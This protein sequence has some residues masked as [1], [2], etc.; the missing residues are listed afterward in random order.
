[1]ADL[2]A[3]REFVLR[4]GRLLERHRFAYLFEE[5]DP[6]PVLAT[7]LAYRNPD[8]GF[9][10]ALEPDLRTPTSQSVAVQTAMEILDEIGTGT[11]PG[12]AGSVPEST[13]PGPAE[14]IAGAC[15][16]L[17]G[18]TRPDGGIPFALASAESAPHAPWWQPSEAS[19]LTQTAAN[20]AALHRLG[21]EHP[22]LD[23][24][25]RFCWDR[26][27]AL[28]LTGLT[29]PTPSI[30][31]DVAFS[32]AFLDAVPDADRATQALDRIGP[33]LL[34]SGLLA[35]DPS[36]RGDLQTALS[37]SPHPDCRSRRLFEPARIESELDALAGDQRPDG[38]WTFGWPI[39]ND[40]AAHEWRGV[41]T[42]EALKTLR[43][44]GPSD[45]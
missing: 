24:L 15:G 33:G 21:V 12:A 23:E 3:V 28:D 37:L 31:Y 20:A 4:E 45:I 34:D 13:S 9:G 16:F 43:A 26:I 40:A 30:A 14:L 41:V 18:I 32:V 5:G 11:R 44:N 8:G 25:T 10:H 22:A 38:G 42:I 39:W 29:E 36:E 17:G 6:E 7:L 35:E 19:S 2:E 27:D 1:M